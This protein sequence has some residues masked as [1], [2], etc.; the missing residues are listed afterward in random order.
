M[1]LEECTLF[2]TERAVYTV[3]RELYMQTMMY[4]ISGTYMSRDIP[5]SIVG[6]DASYITAR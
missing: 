6:A 5:S 4:E 1:T 3:S 2:N